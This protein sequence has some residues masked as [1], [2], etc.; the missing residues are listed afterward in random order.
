MKGDK[1]QKV[2]QTILEKYKQKAKGSES[3]HLYA[4]NY[5][6]GGDTRAVTYFSP[7]PVYMD[8]GKGCYLYDCDGNEYIDFVNN[9]ASLIHDHVHSRIVEVVRSQLEKGIVLASPVEVQYKHAEHLC[10]R[11]PAMDMVRYCNSGTEATLF[12]MRAARAFAGK[13]VIINDGWRLSRHS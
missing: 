11:I 13:D 4:K 10:N 5:F 3:H 1:S 6:P 7:Y 2:V 9:M 12:A 8:R